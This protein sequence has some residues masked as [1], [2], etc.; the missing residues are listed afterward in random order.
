MKKITPAEDVAAPAQINQSLQHG[1]EILMQ[2]A[3]SD[4][5]AGSR[6]LARELGMES[7]HVNRLLGTLAHMGLARRTESHKYLVGDGI[8]VLAALAIRGSRLLNCARPHLTHLAKQSG[9]NAALG[10]LWGTQVCYLYFG[11]D[12]RTLEAKVAQQSLYPAADS[13]IGKILL[14]AKTD[15]A[16]KRLYP[17]NAALLREIHAIRAQ[18]Y[19]VGVAGSVAVLVGNAVAGLALYDLP[20]P[21][22][23][24]A[25]VTLLRQ[26]AQEMQA[27]LD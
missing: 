26:I 3:A 15:E 14:A 27:E 24:S 9:A 1:L 12:S 25:Q 22:D 23:L 5:P 17:D 10:V 18:G 7:T 11:H 21:H 20:D 19:A 13:S 8:H 6:E 2:L 16:L 4:G